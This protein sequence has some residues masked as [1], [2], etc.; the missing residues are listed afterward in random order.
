MIYF[1]IPTNTFNT[2]SFFRLLLTSAGGP[3]HSH[4]LLWCLVMFCDV[5]DSLAWFAFF[6]LSLKK[7]FLALTIACTMQH[8][9]VSICFHQPSWW[10]RSAVVFQRLFFIQ[11]PLQKQKITE[12]RK[13][14]H[15]VF[16]SRES[17]GVC[18]KAI[19]QLGR[20]QL[21]GQETFVLGCP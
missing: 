20:L 1:Q 11:T 14:T 9:T 5:C 19:L 8:K 21:S 2:L 10:P 7:T 18:A 16:P 12:N 4:N 13:H 3:C 17:S 15:P 6:V